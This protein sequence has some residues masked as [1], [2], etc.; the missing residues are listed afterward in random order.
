MASLNTSMS[1]FSDITVRAAAILS[2]MA[3]SALGINAGYAANYTCLECDSM[4][5]AWIVLLDAQK[6]YYKRSDAHK[7]SESDN[8]Y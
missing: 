6:M 2:I 1:M 7:S 4:S 5:A 3:A 8:M